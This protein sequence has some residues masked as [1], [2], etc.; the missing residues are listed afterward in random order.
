MESR[1]PARWRRHFQ[2]SALSPSTA[3]S[4]SGGLRKIWRGLRL[5]ALRQP[6]FKLTVGLEQIGQLAGHALAGF[7]GGGDAHGLGRGDA[8]E[9]KSFW[10]WLPL[11]PLPWE[12]S[13]K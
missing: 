2:S 1:W 3:G 9:V 13:E 12:V 6:V 10:L 5:R 4:R 7:A 11:P 8:M